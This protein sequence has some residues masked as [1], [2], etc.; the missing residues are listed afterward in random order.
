MQGMK[1]IP[2]IWKANEKMVQRFKLPAEIPHS[3]EERM[4][5][6][7]KRKEQSRRTSKVHS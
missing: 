4:E 2:C 5:R 3:L 1:G 6:I 7:Q